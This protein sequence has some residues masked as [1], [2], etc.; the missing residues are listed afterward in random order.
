MFG[1]EFQRWFKIKIV[2]FLVLMVFTS[3]IPNFGYGI[4][5]TG[6]DI[7][8]L[9]GFPLFFYGYGGGPTLM[10]GQTTPTAFSPL[11]L[12]IDIAVWYLVAN[13]TVDVYRK[14]VKKK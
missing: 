1:K 12:V 14:L 11:F 10:Q 4:W 5:W 13:V 3:V 6:A 7:G 2:L 9:Y 8:V